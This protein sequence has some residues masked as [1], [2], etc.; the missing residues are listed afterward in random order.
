M[1]TLITSLTPK[2]GGSEK[3]T[4]R[5]ATTTRSDFSATLYEAEAM[6]GKR[7][8]SF[9]GEPATSAVDPPRF[10][11]A[12]QDDP[13]GGPE[14][15]PVVPSPEAVPDSRQSLVPANADDD[16]GSELPL[17]ESASIARV[18]TPSA[19]SPGKV[20][21][22]AGS[23]AGAREP[24]PAGAQV[25][26]D[27]PSP[28]RSDGVAINA[29]VNAPALSSSTPTTPP[30]VSPIDGTRVR[31]GEAASVRKPEAVRRSLPSPLE[32]Q[33]I[34]KLR[35]VIRKGEAHA[36]IRLDPPDLG[37]VAVELVEKDGELTALL[38]TEHSKVSEA[39]QRLMQEL[40]D[41]FRDAGVSLDRFEVKEEGPGFRDSRADDE[42]GSSFSSR[43]SSSLEEEQVETGPKPR[44]LE[45][46][47]V[48]VWA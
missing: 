3:T 6:K 35:L 2:Q 4:P 18:E 16:Q 33:L 13:E 15:F 28:A 30:P 47:I 11:T 25:F 21:E 5:A 37:R 46:A 23:G 8:E 1:N 41:M 26:H 45:G 39:L 19:E 10:L 42:R 44:A 12:P 17:L 32:A 43:S 20:G 7:R 36:E 31:L 38:R 29:T 22:R 40:R 9:G 24:W 14:A 27:V 48:D 34:E